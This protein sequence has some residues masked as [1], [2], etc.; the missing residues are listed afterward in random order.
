MAGIIDKVTSD[1]GPKKPAPLVEPKTKPRQP[2]E[3]GR[4]QVGTEKVSEPSRTRTGKRRGRPPGSKDSKPRKRP[5]ESDAPP[6][7]EATEVPPEEREKS[8]TDGTDSE[9]QPDRESGIK[10]L[11]PEATRSKIAFYYKRIKPSIP[12]SRCERR[13][14]EYELFDTLDK[15]THLRCPKC[16]EVLRAA[17]F[18]LE[19][20]RTIQ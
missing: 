7:V 10:A 11:M 20:E 19:E 6:A 13:P 8:E 12:C 5:G 2:T 1:E 18:K 14:A 3:A 15:T 4:G 16:F 17:G 9:K